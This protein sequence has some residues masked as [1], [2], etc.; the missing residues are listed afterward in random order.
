MAG[1]AWAELGDVG[2]G[3]RGEG[4]KGAKGGGSRRALQGVGWRLGTPSGRIFV[5]DAQL[6]ETRA[7]V[8]GIAIGWIATT[9]HGCRWARL[10]SW[11]QICL[12]S[13]VHGL[14][15]AGGGVLE[16]YNLEEDGGLNLML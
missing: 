7:C 1:L 14:G 5:G 8:W 12:G 6:P 4:G 13:G 10:P 16:I 11:H 15:C 2:N 3:S 9:H